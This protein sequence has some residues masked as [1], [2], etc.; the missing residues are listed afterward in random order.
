MGNKAKTQ[1]SEATKKD[2]STSWQ[3]VFKQRL[4][5]HGLETISRP[6]HLSLSPQHHPILCC[7]A[8]T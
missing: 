6:L 2:T 8:N 5:V 3:E 7:P 4:N 1:R